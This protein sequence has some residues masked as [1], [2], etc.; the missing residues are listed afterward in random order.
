ML[1]HS[2]TLRSTPSTRLGVLAE[3]QRCDLGQITAPD[4]EVMQAVSRMKGVGDLVS[5]QPFRELL[6]PPERG[7][8]P[9]ATDPKQLQLLI[10]SLRILE[11]CLEAALKI[12]GN[13]RTESRHCAEQV[14]V[15]QTDLQRVSATHGEPHDG[16]VF[17]PAR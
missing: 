4:G 16:A 2:E 10:C 7:V 15:T 14:Q 11:Q 6:V 8:L 3:Q 9:A 12:A 5:R 13:R 1:N 17:A